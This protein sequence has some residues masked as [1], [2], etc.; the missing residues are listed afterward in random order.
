MTVNRVKRRGSVGEIAA[1]QAFYVLPKAPSPIEV[2]RFDWVAWRV[3]V[4][5]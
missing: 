1:R 5:S 2:T 3:G 4:E